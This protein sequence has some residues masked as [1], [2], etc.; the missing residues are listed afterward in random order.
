MIQI[1][2]GILAT[3]EAEY[4]ELLEQL[5]SSESLQGGWVQLDLMDG[6]FVNNKSVSAEVIKKYPSDFQFEAQLMVR[7]PEVW[8]RE[9]GGFGIKRFVAPIEIAQASLEQFIEMC[10][11]NNY[12][13]GLSI[14]PETPVEALRPWVDQ[15]DLILVMSVHPG[16]GGQEFI[17]ESIEK[18]KQIKKMSK[19]VL[20]EVDGGVTLDLV[21]QLMA[22]GADELVMGAARL[23]EG[24]IDET[25]EKIWETIES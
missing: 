4:V 23:I 6:E 15:A 5:K 21:P 16:H 18:I 1:I 11:L 14:N 10:K 20:I 24:G 7:K 22:A 8:V 12:Q 3:N 2:P 17:P 19:Q 9:L 25:F 13:I